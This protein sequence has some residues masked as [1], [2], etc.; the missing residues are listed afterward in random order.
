MRDIEIRDFVLRLDSVSREDAAAIANDVAQRLAA[1]VAEWR[2]FD[3]TALATV[4]VRVPS[5]SSP[6]AIARRLVAEIARLR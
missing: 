1:S 5:G 2:D 3:G 4:H 6:D